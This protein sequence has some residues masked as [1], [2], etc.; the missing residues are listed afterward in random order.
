MP[1]AENGDTLIVVYDQYLGGEN[2]ALNTKTD[3]IVGASE[4]YEAVNEALLG[5]KVGD[6]LMVNVLSGT[7]LQDE[8][9]TDVWSRN[10]IAYVYK[11]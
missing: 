9:I 11:K 1:S 6:I 8:Y 5:S 3:V 10:T 7:F 2:I 4:N